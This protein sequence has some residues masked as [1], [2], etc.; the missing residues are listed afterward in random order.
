MS[1]INSVIKSSA[2]P[3]GTTTITANG[4]YDVTDFASADV[5]NKRSE[6]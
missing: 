3:T 2:K 6:R 1:I 5:H 4:V